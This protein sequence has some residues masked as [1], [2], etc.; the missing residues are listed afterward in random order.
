MAGDERCA[1]VRFLKVVTGS[2]EPPRFSQLLIV[3]A[4]E[5]MMERMMC[6]R[7]TTFGV[8]VVL[9]VLGILT[10]LFSDGRGV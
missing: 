5:R 3:V 10:K 1:K 2:D 8:L 9:S 6:N 4:W 7:T